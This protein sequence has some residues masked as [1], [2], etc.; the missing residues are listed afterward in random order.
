MDSF[1]TVNEVAVDDDGMLCHAV[2]SPFQ[3][4]ETSIRVLLPS[5]PTAGALLKA[6]YVL[7]VARHGTQPW[8]DGLAEIRKHDFHNKYGA[9]FVM[10]TFSHAPW[11][12]DHPTDQGIQQESY[13]LQVVVPFIESHYPVQATNTGRLL[14]GFS[15][16]GWGA[17]SLLLRQPD[18]FSKAVAWDAPLGQPSPNKYGMAEVFPT[19]ASLDPYNVWDL[20][21]AKA[22]ILGGRRR[23]ALLGYGVFRAHHQA[24]HYRMLALGI[25]H[26]YQ[27]GP[28]REHTWHSGW[29]PE[30]V[31]FLAGDDVN[32]AD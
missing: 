25:D 1:V 31:A 2:R 4:G 6:V 17:Y 16:S 13:F 19:Q 27:D 7:P 5:S 29:I 12:A 9:A 14:L 18:Q 20:L 10:P 21:E 30:A 8:G 23:L 22:G 26:E 3:A 24:T 28:E 32:V 11:Y 15:K